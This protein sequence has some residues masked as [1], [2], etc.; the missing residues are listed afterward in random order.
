MGWWKTLHDQVNPIME[1]LRPIPPIAWIPLSI[2]WFGIGDAQNQFI[3]DARSVL[4]TDIVLVGMLTIGLTGFVI[5][6]VV[7]RLARQ[8]LPWSLA[9]GK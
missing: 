4:R 5:D 6:C 3:N 8:L 2:L 1:T 7:R 9:L